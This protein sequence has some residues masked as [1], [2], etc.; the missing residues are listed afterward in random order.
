[1]P[2]P[3]PPAPIASN[4][5]AWA[6][7]A[8]TDR[9]GRWA[10]LQVGKAV[11]R[12]R[13]IEPGEF[14][15]GSPA[16]EPQRGSDEGPQ[17]RVLVT[18]GFWLADT[19]CTQQ[20]WLEVVGGKNPSRF[21]GDPHLPVENVSHVQVEDEFLKRLQAKLP[22]Q[23]EVLLPTEAQWEYAC[24]A[25]TTTPFSF[26]LQ[27]TPDQVNYDGNYPYNG[28]P[29][30]KYVERTVG[31]KARP[32]NAWGLYQMHGNVW[33]WCAD[34]RRP[35]SAGVQMDPEGPVLAGPEALRAVRGGSWI[36][37]AGNCRSAYRN[38]NQRRDSYVILGLRFALRST[39]Q[40]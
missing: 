10:E 1:M 29:K 36:L 2:A 25:K 5:P 30:G 4:R 35:Y 39:S 22:G 19:A 33:E 15:M 18:R 12:L 17:H 11:Q 7:E 26:G 40:A 27:I 6:S 3:P 20:L 38:A 32:A 31:V 14:M 23:P 9:Y 24:R 16:N 13:W 28:G 8:G 34:D 37:G 21:T